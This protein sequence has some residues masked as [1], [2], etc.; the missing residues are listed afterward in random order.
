MPLLV[1]EQL[2]PEWFAAHLGRITSS[3]A[4]ACLGYDPHRGPLAA[5]RAIVATK[6]HSENWCTRWGSDNEARARTA[7]EC[8]TGNLVDRTGFWTHP[9]HDWL[10]ASPDGFV[11]DDGMVELKCPQQLP[12]AVPLNYEIQMGVQMI[13][14]ERKWC[15][16]F[17][18]TP[19]GTF[20]RRFA[21]SE[22]CAATW[23]ASLEAFY[24]EFILPRK[25]PPLRR[26]RVETLPVAAEYDDT[27]DDPPFPLMPSHP[28]GIARIQADLVNHLG[29]ESVDELSSFDCSFRP[30]NFLPDLPRD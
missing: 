26:R 24:K 28:T 30:D 29:V 3:T 25:E 22:N 27:A 9:L 20:L 13:V 6:E 7:Y 8:A 2:S 12:D 4:A 16:F 1:P 17:A 19:S 23:L 21:M 15:D 5:Y 11:G 18:W 10:G 14:C